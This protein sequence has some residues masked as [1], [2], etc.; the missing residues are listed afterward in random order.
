M[1]QHRRSSSKS[2]DLA[3]GHN[4]QTHYYYTSADQTV[5]RISDGKADKEN[6]DKQQVIENPVGP[7]CPYRT[8][9]LSDFTVQLIK[10]W[11]TLRVFAGS[12]V[13]LMQRKRSAF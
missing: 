11:S 3:P 10:L 6:G 12:H 2:G 8:S 1:T 9:Q 7:S 13:A 5:R 4:R